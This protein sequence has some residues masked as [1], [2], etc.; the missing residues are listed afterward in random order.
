MFFSL[1]ELIFIVYFASFLIFNE[2]FIEGLSM[3]GRDW[4]RLGFIGMRDWDYF[5]Y[6]IGIKEQILVRVSLVE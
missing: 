6:V 1:A 2:F 5:Y 4:V 3:D